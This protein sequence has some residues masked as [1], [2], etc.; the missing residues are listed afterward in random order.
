MWPVSN[1]EGVIS[2]CT[3]RLPGLPIKMRFERVV[4]LDSN[5]YS[6]SSSSSTL[7]KKDLSPLVSIPNGS[8]TYDDKAYSSNPVDKP[9]TEKVNQKGLLKK[10]RDLLRRY[11]AVHDPREKKSSEVLLLVT[12]RAVE[13]LMASV[14]SLDA[15]TLL[16]IMDSYT[17]SGKPS[18][19]FEIFEA[20]VGLSS[21]G[22]SSK[23]T[24]LIFDKRKLL[25]G[26]DCLNIFTA[27]A[28]L[29]AHALGGDYNAARRVLAA[30]VGEILVVNGVQSIRWPG[31]IKPD[32]NS[33]NTVIYAAANAGTSEALDMAKALY[34]SMAEPVLFPTARPKKTLITYNT[35]ISA[36]ARCGR[37]QE[38]FSIFVKMKDAG[39][40]PD[41]V[42]VTSLIKAAVEDGDLR[43]GKAL[44]KD[45]KKAGIEA[46]VVTYNTLIKAYCERNQMFEAKELV[47]E[48]ESR[49]IQPD[50]KTYGLLM[51]A[52]LKTGR[53]DACL[54]LFES[55]CS[56]ER[57]VAITEN[58]QLY[59]T[60]VT[61]A[62]SM[63]DFDRALDLISRMTFSGI[64]PNLKTMTALMSASISAGKVDY[65]LEVYGKISNPDGQA[66][67]LALKAYCEK[68]DFD[69]VLPSL[70][71]QRSDNHS[72][73]GK[74]MMSI[75][76]FF[77]EKSL[78]VGNYG[79]AL[80]GMVSF[81]I[82][83]MLYILVSFYLS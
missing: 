21:D 83:K 80:D 54:T 9:I 45:M 29:R 39:I 40:N 11:R 79:I 38:A 32:T 15:K 69:R 30:M 48:M 74:Q 28:L 55:A 51:N 42:S 3:S 4:T 44:L 7:P 64:K 14:S 8:M 71:A 50:A 60:A 35:M 19:A 31:N 27:T 10:V 24:N 53:P 46:D 13:T 20:A 52:L 47:V 16:L 36:F 77:I 70:R 61:A 17:M 37:R 2:A 49:G 5:K 68:G 65:A 56:D 82:S 81:M 75:Y 26:T 1:V 63:G 22:S 18:G 34:D 25:P 76:N 12:E 6:M 59:T 66:M 67:T 43:A 72:M 62:A 41:R 78:A 73:T 33:Y 23:R 58:I 57:T